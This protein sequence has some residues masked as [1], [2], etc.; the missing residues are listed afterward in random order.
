MLFRSV[1]DEPTV[2]KEKPT[3]SEKISFREL[4]V[5]AKVKEKPT[6]RIKAVALNHAKVDPEDFKKL[7]CCYCEK[8]FSDS[9]IIYD[10]LAHK[11]QIHIETI[12]TNSKRA[13]SS[14]A[15]KYLIKDPENP[16]RWLCSVDNCLKPF[17]STS[18]LGKH[19]KTKHQIIMSEA[20]AQNFLCTFCGKSF[21]RKDYRDTHEK[22]HGPK[23][24]KVE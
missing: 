13:N 19:L 21:T 22:I 20:Y 7:I 11:H 14:F 3:Q 16:R 10:H 1:K 17:F 5:M 12:G 24:P 6:S 23:V 4:S 15:K 9:R 8:S 2:N 18:N